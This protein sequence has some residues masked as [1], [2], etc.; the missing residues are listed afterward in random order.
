[1]LLV[2]SVY[3]CIHV[4]VYTFIQVNKTCDQDEACEEVVSEVQEHW[5]V[6]TYLL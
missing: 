5:Y 1:M 4:H 6:A 3:T 2:L